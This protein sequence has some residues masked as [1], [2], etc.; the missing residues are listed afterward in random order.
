M[1][2][3][4]AA[5][6]VEVAGFEGWM[7]GEEEGMGSIRVGSSLKTDQG[8]G[9]NRM[10][11]RKRLDKAGWGGEDGGRNSKCDSARPQVLGEQLLE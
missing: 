5:A 2:E 4:S 3:D 10:Y 7:G 8:T 11:R 9:K 1:L 6:W